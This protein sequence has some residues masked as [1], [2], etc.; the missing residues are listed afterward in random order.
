LALKDLLTDAREAGL[1]TELAEVP[2]QARKIVRRVLGD[3]AKFP[4]EE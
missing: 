3:A 1:D 2:S 4:D